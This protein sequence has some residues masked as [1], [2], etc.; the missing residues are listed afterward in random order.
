VIL[1]TGG[2][3]FLG[4]HVCSLLSRQ[5][6]D[7]LAVDRVVPESAPCPTAAGDLTDDSFLSSLF[8]GRRV[9]VIIHLASLLNTA[10]RRAPQE[11]LRV[12]VGVSLRLIDLAV[13]AGVPRFVFGSSISA[14]G[15]GRH[16][17]C[18]SV[19]EATPAAPTNVYGVTKRY[20]EIVGESS[21]SETGLGFVALRLPTVVGAGVRGT[22]SLWRGRLFERP[23]AGRGLKVEIPFLPAERVPLAHVED[24]AA[25][26][27]H[28]AT[29][30]E[31][32]HT[33]YNSPAETWTCGELADYVA[34]LDT[35]IVVVCGH[36]KVEGIP[37]VVDCQR[38]IRAFGCPSTPIRDWLGKGLRRNGPAPRPGRV[39]P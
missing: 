36:S 39:R 24:V 35:G 1:V 9:D 14:Y 13:R 30:R 3:G 6:K 27:C 12:N 23:A 22:L 20:V 33:L 16:G 2:A 18:S 21:R 7:V 25:A 28:V 31:V 10:S 34:S 5:G 37:Q 15:T 11:A 32:P 26:L 29:A 38:F 8:Q 17:D 19:S 4:R